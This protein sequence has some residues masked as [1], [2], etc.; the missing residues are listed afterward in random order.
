MIIPD[1]NVLISALRQDATHHAP[2]VAW[3]ESAVAGP[4][5]L[6]LTTAVLGGAVRILTHPRVFA[7]PST[8][9][10]VLGRIDDL[11]ATAGV[12][13]VGPGPRH[14][15]IFARLCRDADAR[16][17]LVADAQHAAIAIEHG[18]TWVTFDRDFAR[19]DGLH[20]RTPLD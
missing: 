19:F 8:L 9:A 4:E 1:V 17:S 5:P 16:G 6:G 20:R 12:T 3:L 13:L 18:A 2:A 11:V 7:R 15:E 14:W 10:E